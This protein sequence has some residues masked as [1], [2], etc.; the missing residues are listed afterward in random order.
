[1]YRTQLE[2]SN[3]FLMGHNLR[4]C[5]GNYCTLHNRSDHHMRHMPQNWREDAGFMERICEHGVGHPDPDEI[6]PK[7]VHGCDGCCIDWLD[8]PIL[9]ERP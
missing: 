8:E 9:V 3:V 4:S 7:V 5:I 6:N 2:H 1:M